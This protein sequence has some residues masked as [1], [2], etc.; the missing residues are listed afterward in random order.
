M[1]TLKKEWVKTNFRVIEKPKPDYICTISGK[2]VYPLDPYNP[3][4]QF[5]IV[6]IAHA[7][8]FTCRYNG[9]VPKFYSVAEH[10]VL[11]SRY[12]KDLTPKQRLMLLLHDASE[13]YL[14]D[15]PRPV[16][17]SLPE[18]RGYE[19]ALMDIIM[20][21]FGVANEW[22]LYGFLH[23]EIDM[24]MLAIEKR[25]MFPKNKW[26]LKLPP[27]YNPDVTLKF[28]SPEDAKKEF[29]TA[30][31]RFVADSLEPEIYDQNRGKNEL[32]MRQI[33]EGKVGNR[34][35]NPFE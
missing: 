2:K 21:S 29:L 13:A 20:K 35:Y 31:N 33:S 5:D 14:S 30:Y 9:H 25:D 1:A 7:L 27:I 23:S 6:D 34:P 16:K 15:V 10:S 32:Y 28:L 8:A 22:A 4:N 17:V 12:R 18:Y 24:Q 11:A 26:T 19:R 3:E